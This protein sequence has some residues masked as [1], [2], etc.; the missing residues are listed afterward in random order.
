MKLGW[1][2]LLGSLAAIG[3]GL[4][5]GSGTATAAFEDIEVSPRSRG[6]GKAFVALELDAWAPY[7][8]QAA[9]AWAGPF[10]IAGSYVQPF[11]TN[12][13]RQSVFTGVVGIGRFGGLGVG[14]RRF[15]VDFRGEDLTGETTVTLAHGF[16]FFEDLQSTVTAGWAL[17]VYSLDYGVSVDDVDPGS[18]TTVGLDVSAQALVQ[19]RT[20]VGF[21]AM[22]I[23]NP[24]IGKVD[25]EE[26]IRRIGAGISYAPYRGVIT[27]FDI[28]SEQGHQ[29]QFR[30]G[31]EFK[32][33]DFLLLRGGLHTNPSVFTFGAGFNW[34]GLRVDYGFSSGGGVLDSSHQFGIEYAFPK[35]E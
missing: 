35:G 2:R 21:Y 23:N 28:V 4:L 11:G 14:L 6:M 16:K 32:I 31:V 29:P 20:R 17:N 26:L 33:V 1:K 22:N 24:K 12:F 8:N 18:A 19:R 34:R 3:C 15:D 27:L 5:L 13:S 10:E 30:G 7:H 9:L 25:K